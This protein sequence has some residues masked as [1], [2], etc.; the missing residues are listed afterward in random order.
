MAGEKQ[1]KPSG[2]MV[3]KGER[4]VKF[5]DLIRGIKRN[6]KIQERAC[7]GKKPARVKLNFLWSGIK[8]N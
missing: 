1:K 2:Q 6:P 4:I 8:N 7:V 5:T 3:R